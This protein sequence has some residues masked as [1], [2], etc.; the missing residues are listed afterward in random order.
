MVELT[1]LDVVVMETLVV[2]DHTVVDLVVLE[3][4]VVKD[5]Q[6]E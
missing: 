2:S 1:T 5:V 3:K 6:V 4:T